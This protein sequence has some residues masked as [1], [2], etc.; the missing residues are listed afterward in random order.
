M[1]MT[2]HLSCA[3][4]GVSISQSRSKAAAVAAVR[5]SATIRSSVRATIRP[6]HC[7]YPVAS[8]VSASSPAY[9][10]EEYC[11]RRVPLSLARSRPTRPAACHVVPH[12]S[13]PCSRSTTSVQPSCARW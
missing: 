11:T 13:V 2:G 10:S 1:A 4:S 3:C 6:P 12:D 5:R 7:R 8:P 9:S